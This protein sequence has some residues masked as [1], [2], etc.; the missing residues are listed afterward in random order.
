MPQLTD[1]YGY[2]APADTDALDADALAGH[3]DSI[4]TVIRAGSATEAAQKVADVV[5]PVLVLR[6]DTRS[7]WL[8]SQAYPNGERLAG[9]GHG[10]HWVA[11]ASGVN[12]ELVDLIPLSFV[13]ASAG[14]AMA[15]DE[16]VRMPASGMFVFSAT[17]TLDALTVGRTFVEIVVNGANVARFPSSDYDS[18]SGA[19][20]WPIGAGDLVKVRAYQTSGERRRFTANVLCAQLSDPAWVML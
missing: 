11:E 2:T 1:Q 3:L 9:G 19:C 12:G 5:L 13:K 10:A 4:R 20:L 14:F 6:T 17:T 15:T 8:Y 18:W 16:Q 7:L